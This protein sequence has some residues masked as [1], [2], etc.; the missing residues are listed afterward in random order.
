MLLLEAGLD[1]PDLNQLPDMLKYGWGTI[2]LEA[3][4]AGAPYN[5][6]FVGTANAR[7]PLPM[8][9]PRGKVTGGTSAINGQTFGWC[10]GPSILWLE[11]VLPCLRLPRG[12]FGVGGGLGG[13]RI[14]NGCCA[15]SFAVRPSA[16]LQLRPAGS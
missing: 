8:P 7:Q 14:T 6:S 12:S 5:W 10:I 1:F 4:Q 3:R 11:R 2:N 9:V 13:Y 15:H 16:S